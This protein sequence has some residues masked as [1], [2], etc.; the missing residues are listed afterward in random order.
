M[1]EKRQ[2]KRLPVNLELE[3]SSLFHQ[4][5]VNVENIEAP[6]EVVDI[7]KSGIGF[8]TSS[9][10]PIDYYFNAKIQLGD[11]ESILYTVVKIIRVNKISDTE[12]AYGC[13]LVGMAPVLHYIFDKYEQELKQSGNYR[14]V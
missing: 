7:S 11:E 12:F 6:I 2:E 8:H 4:D 5:N 1:L 13:E 9:I 10:L 14:E 3:I